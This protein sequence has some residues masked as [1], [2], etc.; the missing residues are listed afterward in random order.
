MP[1]VGIGRDGK[2]HD[3]KKPRGKTV[4]LKSGAKIRVRN[5]YFSKRNVLV[6]RGARLKWNIRA[7]G[8]GEL[9]NV[10]LASGPRGFA[11]P[12]YR[13]HTF[14]YRFRKRGKYKIFCALHPVSMT[15]VVTVR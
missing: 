1:I 9:H 14:R 5:F 15:E 2:A 12:N 11:S 6:R 10:T 3:I 4:R 8:Q 13:K 7:K